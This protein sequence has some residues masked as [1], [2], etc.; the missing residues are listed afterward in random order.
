[1]SDPALAVEG[2]FVTEADWLDRV[3]ETVKG[4]PF[5]P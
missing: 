2:P 5:A 1:M 3:R 4:A